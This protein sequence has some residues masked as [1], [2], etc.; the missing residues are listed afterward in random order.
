MPA[1]PSRFI[2]LSALAPIILVCSGCVPGGGEPGKTPHLPTA[3]HEG[4]VPGIAVPYEHVS[5]AQEEGDLC[6]TYRGETGRTLLL[7]PP[8]T[9]VTNNPLEI[10]LN[11]QVIRDGDTFYGS[12]LSVISGGHECGGEHFDNAGVVS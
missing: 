3:T 12:P 5:F 9:V 8:D 7:F 1:I 10:T 6:V 2:M 4:P 11:D